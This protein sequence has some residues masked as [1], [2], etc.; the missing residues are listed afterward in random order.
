MK[1]SS[2]TS[3]RIAGS[4][5][6]LVGLGHTW[7]YYGAFVTRELLDPRRL[8]AYEAMKEP[9]DGG[10]MDPSFWTVLQMLGLE[11]T[12]FLGFAAAVTFWIAGKS[13]VALRREFALLA[14]ITFGLGVPAFLFIHPQIHAFVIATGSFLLF[15]V[16]W[17]QAKSE[18][19]V[20]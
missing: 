12:F 19:N 16:S 4:W 9:M 15:G 14:T 11:L 17:R 10:M 5:L 6:V 7:G 2:K 1:L 20:K 3:L 18:S 8:P 13:D